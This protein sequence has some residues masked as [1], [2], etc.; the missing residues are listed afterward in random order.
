MS[1]SEQKDEFVTATG[2]S[3]TR[4]FKRLKQFSSFLMLHETNYLLLF[5]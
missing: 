4:Q 1:S 2:L 5:R 3:N